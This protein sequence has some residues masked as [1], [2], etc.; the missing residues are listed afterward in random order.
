MPIATSHPPMTLNHGSGVP[1]GSQATVAFS[2][3]SAE[4]RPK[5][6]KIPNQINMIPNE[7]LIA[8]VLH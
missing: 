3:S 4:D 2:I 5:G 6:F 1:T 8:G 7:I